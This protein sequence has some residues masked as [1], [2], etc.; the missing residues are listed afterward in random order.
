M[1]TLES[2]QPVPP[3]RHSPLRVAQTSEQRCERRRSSPLSVAQ[4]LQNQ[5]EPLNTTIKIEQASLPPLHNEAQN[6][7]SVDATYQRMKRSA[8]RIAAVLGIQKPNLDRSSKSPCRAHHH[9]QQQQQ[10]NSSPVRD[11][12]SREWEAVKFQSHAKVSPLKEQRN[13]SRDTEEAMTGSKFA[14]VSLVSSISIPCLVY[15]QVEPERTQGK[16]AATAQGL[17]DAPPLTRPQQQC[18]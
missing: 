1:H 7:T 12:V 18:A 14:S 6:Y 10:Q 17:A 4:A 5:H 8:D 15:G 16:D 2:W 3:A 11:R 9:Q 13:R